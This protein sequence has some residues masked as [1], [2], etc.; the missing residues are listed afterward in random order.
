MKNSS[1]QKNL[2]PL[3]TFPEQ[4]LVDS[5]LTAIRLGTGASW[6]QQAAGL[7]LLVTDDVYRD[8]MPGRLVAADDQQSSCTPMTLRRNSFTPDFEPSRHEMRVF[9][10]LDGIVTEM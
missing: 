3:S 9:D 1:D 2:R 4:I 8:K 5:D 6:N 7:A 10:D